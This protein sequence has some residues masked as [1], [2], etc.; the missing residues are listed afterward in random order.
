MVEIERLAIEITRGFADFEEFLDFGVGDI[1]ID[2]GG[3]AAQRPLR[4]GEGEAVHDADERDD[5]AGLAIQADRFTDAADIAPIGA[6]A[7]AA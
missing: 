7:A 5:A 2:G 1:E 6:D 4:N 3:T